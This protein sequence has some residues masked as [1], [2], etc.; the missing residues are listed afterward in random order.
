MKKVYHIQAQSP[1]F[2]RRVGN[3]S[4]YHAIDLTGADAVIPD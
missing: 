3:L 1:F 2:G 4:M